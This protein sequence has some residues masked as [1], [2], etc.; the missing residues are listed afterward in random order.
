MNFAASFYRAAGSDALAVFPL[1]EG[2]SATSVADTTGNGYGGAI[3]GATWV[4]DTYN[5]ASRYSL[6][7]AGASYVTGGTLPTASYSPNMTYS[8]WLKPTTHSTYNGIVSVRAACGNSN[9][10]LH[11]ASGQ[12]SAHSS[13]AYSA[14]FTVPLNKWTHVAG[15]INSSNL[16]SLYANGAFVG[17]AT[18]GARDSSA[19]PIRIGTDGTC[20]NYFVGN[21]DDVRVYNT[22]L[23]L[24]QI[25]ELYAEGAAEHFARE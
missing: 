24:S 5:A 14:N 9:F 17:S 13:S 12:L 2:P 7:F 10:Q 19:A 6:N 1:E 11:L 15:T 23:S 18:I 8:A 22:N 20:A 21:I 3:T 16:V 4:T 25:Q